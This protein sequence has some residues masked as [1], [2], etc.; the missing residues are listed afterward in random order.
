MPDANQV[1]VTIAVSNDKLSIFPRREDDVA[2]YCN[3]RSMKDAPQSPEKPRELCWVV[4]GASATQRVHIQAKNPAMGM[5]EREEWDVPGPHG[6]RSA[7]SGF[8][9]ACP[10]QGHYAVWGYEVALYDGAE[11]KDYIDPTIIIKTDP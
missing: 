8:V 6:E 7:R 2:I 5:F 1:L 3:S 10:A 11:R 9:K 4:T